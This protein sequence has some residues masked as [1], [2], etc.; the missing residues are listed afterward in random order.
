M[1]DTSARQEGSLVAAAP[2][3]SPDR[4]LIACRGVC[5]PLERSFAELDEFKPA[6]GSRSAVVGN[7]PPG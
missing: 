1:T 4:E 6:T 5:V 3:L 7:G 2:I